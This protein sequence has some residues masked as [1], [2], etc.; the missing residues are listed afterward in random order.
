MGPNGSLAPSISH[1]CFLLGSLSTEALHYICD[2]L[3]KERSTL[4]SPKP[5]R[6]CFLAVHISLMD[7]DAPNRRDIYLHLFSNIQQLLSV[8]QASE[9]E[10]TLARQCLSRIQWNSMEAGPVASAQRSIFDTN[11]IANLND[12]LYSAW[13]DA[14]HPSATI[15]EDALISLLHLLSGDSNVDKFRIK[16]LIDLGLVPVC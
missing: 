8:D 12:T 10:R 1:F 9:E 6:L 2:Y 7:P 4:S 15:Y 5:M 14:F 13:L 16:R 3:K 11:P